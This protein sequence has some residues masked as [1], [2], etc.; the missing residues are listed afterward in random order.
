M[1]EFGLLNWA[2]VVFYLVINLGLGY[3]MSVRV[4][5]ADDYQL[6]DRSTPGWAIGISVVATYVSALSF[7]GGP[8]WAYGDGMAALVATHNPALAARMDRRL[9]LRGGQI[10]EA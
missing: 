10:E 7:L 6:G 3:A 1:A 8:A 4:K 5:S 2:I 9:R